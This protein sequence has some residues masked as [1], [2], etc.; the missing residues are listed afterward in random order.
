MT[1]SEYQQHA[2]ETAIYGEPVDRLLGADHRYVYAALGLTSEAGEVANKV[3]KIIRDHDGVIDETQKAVVTEELGD[4]LWYT[5]RLASELGL[6]LDDVAAKNVEKLASRKARGT[7]NG[8]G[9]G[10]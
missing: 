3:K 1:L 6:S 4:V 7:L 8:N 9:D 10:R 5:A 2:A